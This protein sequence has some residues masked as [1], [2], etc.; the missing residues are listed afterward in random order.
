MSEQLQIKK[1]KS[2]M[3]PLSSKEQKAIFLCSV[4]RKR[5][6]R[7][8]TGRTVII[9][10]TIISGLEVTLKILSG[11]QY[12]NF[13]L[14]GCCFDG[15]DTLHDSL[16]LSSYIAGGQISSER[17]E[18]ENDLFKTKKISGWKH[19]LLRLGLSHLQLRPRPP[20]P[21]HLQGTFSSAPHPHPA[22]SPGH[23]DRAPVQCSADKCKS[24][25]CPNGQKA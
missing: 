16:F 13:C 5:R 9:W 24:S 23:R 25:G 11:Y 6:R 1:Q 3:S 7:K 8:S 17:F 20:T 18:I 2:K 10:R 4:E 14:L 15:L 19:S 22:A 21:P 12:F